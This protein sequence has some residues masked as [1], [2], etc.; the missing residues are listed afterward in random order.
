MKAR[1]RLSISTYLATITGLF[2]ITAA[3]GVGYAKHEDNY[4]AE[5]QALSQARFAARQSS[6]GITKGLQL[7]AQQVG[8]LAVTPHL[9]TTFTTGCSLSFAG[10]GPFDAG[11]IDVLRP[12]GTVAC[13]SLPAR[14]RA[15]GYEGVPWLRS[16][17]AAPQRYGPLTDPVTHR[18]VMVDVAAIPGGGAAAGFVDLA[19]LAPELSSLYGGPA[20]LEFLVTNPAST[21]SLSRS[22]DPQRWRGTSLAG[23][24]FAR[25]GPG[26]QRRDVDGRWRVYG[27]AVVTGLGWKVYA[28]YDRASALAAANSTF[29]FELSI[30]AVGF[31]VSIT[32]AFFFSR[33]ATLPVRRLAEAVRAWTSGA[34]TGPIDLSGPAEVLVLAQGFNELTTAV[35]RVL[36]QQRDAEKAVREAEASYRH[37]FSHNPQPMW[38][39]DSGTLRFL[40]VNDAAVARFG[41]SRQEFLA[42]TIRDIRPVEDLPAMEAAIANSLQL[43]HSGPWRYLKKDGSTIFVEVS[44]HGLMF[45]GHE[46]RVVMAQ[47]VT[48]RQAYERQLRDLALHDQLTGLANRTVVLDRI[49]LAL[50]VMP[51]HWLLGV[52]VCGLDRFKEVNNVHGRAAGDR[53]LQEI[54]ARLWT[55]A[56]PGD[57]LGRVGPDEFA[58][59][60]DHLAGETE[61][62]AMAGRIEGVMSTP[63]EVDGK[64]IFVSASTGIVLVEKPRRADEI[65]RDALAAMHQARAAGGARY[66]IFDASIRERAVAKV[67]LAAALRRAVERG[68]L[69]LFYQP[70]IDLASG[71]CRGAEALMRW[72]HPTRGLVL[73]AEFIPIAEDTGSIL[74]VGRWA[75]HEACRQAAEW[76]ANQG[77]PGEISV[78]LSAHQLALPDLVSQVTEALDQSGLDP[79]A[80]CLELTETALMQDVEG[81]MATLSALHDLGVH[82]SIDDFGTGYSSLLYLR[83]YPVHYL[84]IDRTFVSGL[85][86]GT[87]DAAIA[88]GIISL[89]HSFGLQVVAE[90]VE[91]DEQL[92]SLRLLECDLAQGYLW[93]AP[94][95]AADI[96]AVL[97]SACPPATRDRPVL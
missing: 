51:N 34:G 41:Y 87:Q 18:L 81:A 80:I 44:S 94:V 12:N 55:V 89:G 83:R 78:N 39:Y 68:E 23:T 20:R 54:A 28:G 49:E 24:P 67:E 16:T 61:A 37:L 79:G 43:R 62:V 77:G 19:S 45:A 42:M 29:R 32:A 70:E 57:T 56:A 93:S 7:L 40:A 46:A 15:G 30:I 2:L 17:F 1:H 72:Q 22:L 6:A 64:E 48:Q 66:E 65:M 58:L 71:R 33:R 76:A 63:F 84:K 35:D 92:A 9:S 96:A 91:T 27:V 82:L 97:S 31:L 60:C 26:P 73:P 75:L 90:G 3:V 86:P 5:Q 25:S 85:G 8:Q 47:D 11:Y 74:A 36:G 88:S 59:V 14:A 13:S 38:V 4:N 53:V 95:P 10:T 69:R 50:A 21:E 52:V